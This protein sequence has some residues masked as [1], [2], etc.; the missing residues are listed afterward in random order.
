[1]KKGSSDELPFS[2]GSASGWIRPHTCRTQRQEKK[3]R[4]NPLRPQG[5]R[6]HTHIV[7]IWGPPPGRIPAPLSAPP[8]HLRHP[9]PIRMALRC[10]S[11]RRLRESAPH[12]LCKAVGALEDVCDKGLKNACGHDIFPVSS[13]CPAR[14]HSRHAALRY[15]KNPQGRIMCLFSQYT[16][17]CT[18][19]AAFFI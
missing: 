17:T 12:R 19:E 5:G 2:Y 11:G 4:R 10:G 6:L 7:S 14:F 16:E 1:M 3:E 18:F 9:M 8:A 13:D 15:P